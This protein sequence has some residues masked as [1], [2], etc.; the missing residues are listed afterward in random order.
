MNTVN[1]WIV[2]DRVGT[3]E[4]PTTKRAIYR[5]ECPICG[6]TVEKTRTAMRQDKSC[7]CTK[8]TDNKGNT[9]HGESSTK[10]YR[11]WQEIGRRHIKYPKYYGHIRRCKEWDDF[12]VFRDWALA[13]GYR[14]D[15]TIERIDSD[16]DYS[17][18]NCRW[19]T[20]Q[21]Q[22]ENQ[23]QRTP[24][25][26]GVRGITFKQGKYQAR[27]GHNGKRYHLGYFDE[28]EDAVKA[29]N[30]FITEHNTNHVKGYYNGNN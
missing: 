21:V 6:N 19:D 20:R 30:E 1:D 11:L 25:A 10:L 7:G 22:S 18:D 15:L 2:G 28:L 8:Y 27:I 29:R 16:K 12:T 26:T 23:K 24:T 4:T 17:P 9:K 14:E 5:T 13:S 3:Y